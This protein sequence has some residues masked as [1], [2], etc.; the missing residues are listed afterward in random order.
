M[1]I[2]GFCCWSIIKLLLLSDTFDD[3]NVL[4]MV[5]SDILIWTG[6]VLGDYFPVS[7]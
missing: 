2:V 6:H 5:I 3:Y 4:G 1:L 7:Y